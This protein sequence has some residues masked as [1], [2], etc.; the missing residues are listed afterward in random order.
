MPYNFSVIID[1]QKLA[2]KSTKICINACTQQYMYIYMLAYN[3]EQVYIIPISMKLQTVVVELLLTVADLYITLFLTEDFLRFSLSI[4]FFCSVFPY[5]IC[6]LLLG[7]I[8]ETILFCETTKAIPH[9]GNFFYP[10]KII[11]YYNHRQK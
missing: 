1:M 9:N 2:Y 8:D 3:D 10:S 7:L 4:V 11:S 6:R 5:K